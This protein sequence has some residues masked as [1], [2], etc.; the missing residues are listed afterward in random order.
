MSKESWN[1]IFYVNVSVLT[2]YRCISWRLLRTVV[3][4]K[5]SLPF[6]YTK[7]VQQNLKT[8]LMWHGRRLKRTDFLSK[9]SYKSQKSKSQRAK[10]DFTCV[11]G[12]LASGEVHPV[13]PETCPKIS[14]R[15]YGKSQSTLRNSAPA[16]RCGCETPE[17]DSTCPTISSSCWRTG[18]N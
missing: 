6:V 10:A 4:L 2:V 11:F 15:I 7:S 5:F 16:D 12:F 8:S 18:S 13:G 1:K 14:A 3:F 17:R 9:F